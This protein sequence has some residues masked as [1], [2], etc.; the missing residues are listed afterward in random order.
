[1]CSRCTH[2]VLA[3]LATACM[4]ACLM[5]R[6]GIDGCDV[7]VR[8]KKKVVV[9]AINML[10]YLGFQTTKSRLQK[11]LQQKQTDLLR[12]DEQLLQ[13]RSRCQII[14]RSVNAIEL[15]RETHTVCQT[16][17]PAVCSTCGGDGCA[18]CW[19]EKIFDSERISL[20]KYNK[21][22]YSM[23]SGNAHLWHNTLAC[24]CRLLMYVALP[25]ARL[26]RT[27][28]LPRMKWLEPI[29]L[30]PLWRYV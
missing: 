5:R 14:D 16:Y 20:S 26:K 21:K 8:S 10:A 9:M 19:C 1:M 30:S 28:K 29:L 25:T 11:D 15:T 22:N 12:K 6:S 13:L 7:H 17:R 27:K 2:V 3:R 24:V 23:P 4:H 18:E